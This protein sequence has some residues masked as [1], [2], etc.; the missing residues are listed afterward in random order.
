MSAL[1][2]KYC[3][4]AHISIT[5]CNTE[6]KVILD[7]TT[8]SLSFFLFFFLF[9]FVQDFCQ[10]NKQSKNMPHKEN[11]NLAHD[12]RQYMDICVTII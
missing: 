10:S 4:V 9:A 7:V 3:H 5:F 11:E 2:N 6:K 1:W 8:L 12:Q